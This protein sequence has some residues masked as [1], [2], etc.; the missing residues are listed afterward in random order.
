MLSANCVVYGV[1][2]YLVISVGFMRVNC[3]DEADACENQFVTN[4]VTPVGS[5][6]SQME[7]DAL[8]A[9]LR[10]IGWSGVCSMQTQ[11]LACMKKQVWLE[12]TACSGAPKSEKQEFNSFMGRLNKAKKYMCQTEFKVVNAT[13]QCLLSEDM[14]FAMFV[15][16]TM[17]CVQQSPNAG[18]LNECSSAKLVVDCTAKSIKEDACGS[19]RAEQ[20]IATGLGKWAVPIYDQYPNCQEKKLMKKRSL[21]RLMKLF[22]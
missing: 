13:Y 11:L 10:E 16:S 1:G 12:N 3:F 14:K 2:L 8:I 18:Q 15:L 7:G 21:A 19:D 9:K 4:C 22:V 17:G 6:F 20:V 5:S